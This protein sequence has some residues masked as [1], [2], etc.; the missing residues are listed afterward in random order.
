MVL[1]LVGAVLS[2]CGAAPVA[3]NWPGLTVE[4]DTVY[5]ISGLPQQ[6]YMLDVEN[7][8][9]QGTFIPSGE[10]QGVIYWSPVAPGPEAAYVG[11]GESQTGIMALFAFDP[12]TGR[13]LWRTD[14]EVELSAGPGEVPAPRRFRPDAIYERF[15]A[16]GAG[17]MLGKI[18]G[19][20][21]GPD[22]DARAQWC[23]RSVRRAA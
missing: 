16:Q 22:V 5:V 20:I 4:G 7:G 9:P 2:G 3:Q 18:P 23:S 13:Q 15:S 6:V 1:L 19:K 21:T 17:A 12:E 8:Q 11:F 10:H 14:L